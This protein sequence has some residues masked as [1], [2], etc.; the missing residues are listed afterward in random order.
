M[1]RF[2]QIIGVK[3][4][5]FEKYKKFHKEAWPEVL[6]MIKECNIRN[7]SIFHRDGMLYAYFEYTGVDFESDMARMA[8]HPKTQEW[9]S[10]MEPMQLPLADRADGEWW[11][12]MEEVFHLD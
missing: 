7:Y 10:I 4:Q 9:W 12:N 11:A 5:E 8:I 6:G 1:K 2:G 3:P